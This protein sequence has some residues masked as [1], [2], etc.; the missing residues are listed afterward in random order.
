MGSFLFVIAF[1][2]TGA[3]AAL[4]GRWL[5]FLAGLLFMPAIWAIAFALP[6]TPRS[7]WFAHVYDERHRLHALDARR[8]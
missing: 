2:A 6:A 1:V 3:T 5:V 4:K 8:R 7:W